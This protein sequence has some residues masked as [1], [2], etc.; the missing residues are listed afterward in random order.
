M[1]K[2]QIVGNLMSQLICTLVLSIQTGQTSKIKVKLMAGFYYISEVRARAGS[3]T[4]GKGVQLASK[5]FTSFFLNIPLK[6][7]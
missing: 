3:R 4:S 2:C 5:D 7:I 6:M 1:S